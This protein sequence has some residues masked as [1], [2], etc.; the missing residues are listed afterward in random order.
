MLPVI[1]GE[2]GG[3]IAAVSCAGV[4]KAPP[5]AIRAMYGSRKTEPPL[6][7]AGRVAA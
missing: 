4:G 6:A 5:A 7:V 3:V 1:Q 2:R